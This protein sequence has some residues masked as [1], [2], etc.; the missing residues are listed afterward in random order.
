[1]I[2]PKTE[3]MMKLQSEWN[4]N[5]EL[6]QDLKNLSTTLIIGVSDNP[7]LHPLFFRIESGRLTEVRPAQPQE[8]AEFKCEAP[9]NVWRELISGR[10]NPIVALGALTK[11]VRKLDTETFLESLGG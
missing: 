9:T 11:F 3:W 2:M 6:I 4:S 1:M 5:E 7:E 8:T 10:S